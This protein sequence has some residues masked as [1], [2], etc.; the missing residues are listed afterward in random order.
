MRLLAIAVA[1]LL[2][3]PAVASAQTTDYT[4]TAG[5]TQPQYETVRDVLR[6]PAYDGREL[7]I[8]VT[9]PKATGRFPVILEASPYHGTLADRDGTRILPEPR[10]ADGR[11][12]GLTGY[13]APRGYAVVM[14]DLRGTGRSQGCLDHLGLRDARDLKQIVEWSAGQRWSNGRVGMTGHSYVG[15]TP[16]VAA[17]Q[18]PQGLATIVPSAGLASMYD[19]QFQAGVPYFLQWAGP[20]EAYEQIAIERKLPPGLSDPFGLTHPGDDFGNSPEET[21]CGLPQSAAVSGE[22]QLSGRYSAWHEARDWQDGAT[23]ADIP[24]FLV[25]GV[26]DN[27]ARVAAMDW[28]TGRNGRPGDKLWLGQW[29]HGSGCCPTRRGIQWTY[30]LHA[31]FDKQLAQL[32]VDTGPAVELFMGDGTFSEARGGAREEVA[33][34]DA[35]TKGSEYMT[36]R[37]GADGTLSEGEAGTGSVS[38]EGDP[39]G[40]ADPQGTGAAEFATT[41]FTSDVVLAGRPEMDLDASVTAPRVHLIATLYDERPED[42]DRRRITQWAINP[43]LRDGIANR[44]LVEPGQRYDMQPPGF[45][46]AHHVKPGHR[47]VLRVTTSDP[48]KVPMFA[49]D[50]KVTVF[51]GMDG[52]NVRLP[53]VA[54]PVLAPDDVPLEENTAIP[55][56][57]AQAAIEGTVTPK[58]PGAGVRQGGLTSEYLE[59]EALEGADNARMT[60]L[61]TPSAAA[62]ID[63]YLQRRNAD[64]TWSGDLATGG[65]SSLESETLEFGRLA[66]GTYRLEVHNWAGPPNNAVNVKLTFF[67]STGHAP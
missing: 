59:F 46:M 16:S 11:S 15:S 23:S 44:K 48:D 9:R 31:W 7:Y 39:A 53:V 64:G 22:D 1:L 62:D 29:D 63:L 55:T 45:A 67:D 47:L 34:A 32:P 57:P 51:T 61:A 19:H 13:F 58:A 12:V 43:E 60:A 24:V 66:P 36:L 3:G 14:M 4:K 10:N 25:H 37:P 5:L 56:G 65:S 49:V 42:G 28:F 50:P 20:I 35:W 41:P 26:N 17:A 21:G 52:T 54:N 40:Y 2:A 33:T 38:F 6:V 30:A 27:A 18:D 8:E